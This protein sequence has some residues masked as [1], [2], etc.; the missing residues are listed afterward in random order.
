MSPNPNRDR[1]ILLVL[2]ILLLVSIS[3]LALQT[4]SYFG[5][6]WQ[7]VSGHEMQPTGGQGRETFS[8]QLPERMDYI[9]ENFEAIRA[10][11]LFFKPWNVVE[12]VVVVPSKPAPVKVKPPKTTVEPETKKPEV[13]PHAEQPKEEPVPQP[14]PP[15]PTCPYIVS[16]IL[17]GEPPFA[18]LVN[19]ETRKSQT[20]QVGTV[21]GH[22]T[23]KAIERD[24]VLVQ[25]VDA[26]F[27]LELGGM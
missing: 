16:G 8:V 12:E 15:K 22:F 20:V 21:L 23:V 10:G 5:G 3:Y 13:N 14:E 9:N 11:K 4:A 27:K 24:S 19:Q 25:G 6:S 7:F 1:R 26:E 2:I 17:W 18:I